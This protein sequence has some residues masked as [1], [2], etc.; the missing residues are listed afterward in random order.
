[1]NTHLK[2]VK[3]TLKNRDPVNLDQLSIRGNNIRYYILPDTLPLVRITPDHNPNQ[4]INIKLISGESADRRGTQEEDRDGP[5]RPRSSWW[6]PRWTPWSWQRPRPRRT[7]WRWTPALRSLA[8]SP[9]L[10]IL[11]DRLVNVLHLNKKV[12][13]QLWS[14]SQFVVQ[15]QVFSTDKLLCYKTQAQL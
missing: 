6:R 4:R 3:M 8:F 9:N 10:N 7:S 1:M 15:T 13:Q 2:T 11:K 12:V 5:R 14:F